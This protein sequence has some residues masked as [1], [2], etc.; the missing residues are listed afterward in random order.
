MNFIS[1]HFRSKCHKKNK[2]V[3]LVLFISCTMNLIVSIT[4]PSYMYTS[5]NTGYRS[6][7]T[8]GHTL[9]KL[10]VIY[11]CLCKKYIYSLKSMPLISV[12]LFLN[13]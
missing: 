11:N 8:R 3:F 5:N 4:E 6:T 1:H 9:G 12:K 10:S 13:S 7:H 2:S